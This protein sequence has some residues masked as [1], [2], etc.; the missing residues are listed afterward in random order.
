VIPR[1]ARLGKQA[2]Q[3]EEMSTDL[4][5]DY[6]EDGTPLGIE[7]VSPGYVSMDEIQSVLDH[8]GIERLK[9]AE[10]EPLKAA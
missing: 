1:H 6:A 3:T 7:I 5:V 2:T 8:L 9:P 10:L 4:L